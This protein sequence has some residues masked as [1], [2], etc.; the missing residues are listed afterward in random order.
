MV[1]GPQAANVSCAEREAE[2]TWKT[3]SE[4]FAK[5][6]IL[7]TAVI[8]LTHIEGLGCALQVFFGHFKGDIKCIIILHRE[9]M[10][11]RETHR[12]TTTPSG[13]DHT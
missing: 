4:Q 9:L 7:M 5:G 1:L 12:V 13:E 2:T 11:C 3:V 6:V 10:P 8:M